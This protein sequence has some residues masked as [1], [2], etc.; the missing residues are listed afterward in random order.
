MLGNVRSMQLVK[1]MVDFAHHLDLRVVAE[2]VE[3]RQ[4]LQR[5]AELEC[6]HA[7]GYAIGRA[8]SVSQLIAGLMEEA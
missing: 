6:D 1:A 7:Q 3:D 4:T 8:Q 2:G 5:L